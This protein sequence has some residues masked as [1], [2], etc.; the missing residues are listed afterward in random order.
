M[1]AQEPSPAVAMAQDC[2]PGQAHAAAGL[3]DVDSARDVTTQAAGATQDT[4]PLRPGQL[5]GFAVLIYNPSDVTQRI[6]GPA[7]A[8]SI[9]APVPSQIAVAITTPWNLESSPHAVRYQ[10]GG[11]I[12]PHSYRWVRVLWRSYHCYLNGVGSNQGSNELTVR[13]QLGW[14]TR[15]EDI[16]LPTEFAVSATRANVQPA[17]CQA[18]GHQPTP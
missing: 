7:S 9:G 15:T 11:A 2:H 4:V 10:I 3:A 13:V 14:I 5:Q 18:H 12:P 16:Q 8:I 1:A 6:F 17:Y